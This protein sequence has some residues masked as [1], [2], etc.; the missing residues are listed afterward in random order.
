MQL[1]KL[2]E[3]PAVLFPQFKKNKLR[4]IA[5]GIVKIQL[6]WSY[7]WDFIKLSLAHK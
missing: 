7:T 5:S 1:E 3:K 6:V 4:S 2:Y